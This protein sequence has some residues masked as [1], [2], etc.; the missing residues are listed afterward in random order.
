MFSFGYACL[1][2]ALDDV[3][4][5]TPSH[6]T[7]EA[8]GGGGV[9]AELIFSTCDT[10]VGSPGIQ[11]PM[12]MRPP[13]FVNAHHLLGDVQRLGRKHRA[14]DRNHQIERTVGDT[15]QDC[16]RLLPETS[17]AETRLRGA[18]VPGFHQVPGDVDSQYLRSGSGQRKRRGAI[19]AAEIRNA[20]RRRDR[21][22]LNE[23]LRR[24]DA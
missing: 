10:K 1:A 8:S 18:L 21:E 23:L 2:K 9:N 22:R 12:T 7:D 15:F 13:G 20:Q 11:L 17:L 14:K 5:H 19:S 3:A 16:M 4:L 6:G 24:T